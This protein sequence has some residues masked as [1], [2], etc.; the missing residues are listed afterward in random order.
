MV[1]VK[2]QHVESADFSLP[3][4]RPYGA[5]DVHIGERRGVLIRL[6]STEGLQ[7][8]GEVAPL[9]GLHR[10][11]LA[12]VRAA[13]PEQ[14]AELG[15]R[16]SDSLL[17]L[18]EE[19]AIRASADAPDPHLN[20]L[21]PS[22][23]FGLQMA[24]TGLFAAAAGT[25]PAALLAASPRSR[26]RLAGL[27]NGGIEQAREAIEQGTFGAF[28]S[29]KVKLG[30]RPPPEERDILSCLLE[31][32]GEGTRLR[33]D[34]NRA[35]SLPE[36]RKRLAGLPPARIEYLE[37]PLADPTQLA[38]LS[39]QTGLPIALDES[40][41]E[42]ACRPLREAPGVVAWVVKPARFGEWARLES[43][44]LGARDAG[45]ALVL[46]SCLE[47]GL[48]LSSQVQ[49]AAALP[50][51]QAPAGLATEGWLAGDLIVPPFDSSAGFAETAHWQ[52]RPAEAVLERLTF[53]PVA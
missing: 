31:G 39:S 8:Y 41:H 38:R 52:G 47:S 36:A 37:E 21:Q 14:V 5:G 42:P 44:A 32:L 25:T 49:L 3:C 15:E 43:L 1:A 23:C 2:I 40:L 45:I 51:A 12:E 50:H 20:P 29:L 33:L 17:E 34:A 48:A 27:F 24:I 4:T 53:A 35:F 19:V 30:S 9:P 11:T 46:S 18:L 26:V 7:G 28:S 16:T 6:R 10:E 22:L 13:L